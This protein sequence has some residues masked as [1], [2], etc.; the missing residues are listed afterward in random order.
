MRLLATATA[1][2]TA[3][4]SKEG[5]AA[6]NQEGENGHQR[7]EIMSWI[8]GS[9]ATLVG[10]ASNFLKDEDNGGKGNK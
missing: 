4:R 7:R 10:D 3:P 9:F 2:A 8:V 6:I 1:W 5:T